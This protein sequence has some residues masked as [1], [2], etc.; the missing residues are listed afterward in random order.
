MSDQIVSFSY[1]GVITNIY[2]SGK[3]KMEE[4]VQKFC[5]KAGIDK[6]SVYC[7]Y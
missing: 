2:C 6:S 5:T 3:E 4:I 1:E 7:L